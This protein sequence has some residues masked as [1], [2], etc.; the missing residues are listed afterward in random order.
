MARGRFVC[1]LASHSKQNVPSPSRQDGAHEMR[2]LLN[3][4]SSQQAQGRGLREHD[5][6]T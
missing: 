4:R 6:F 2:R 3:L 1:H 5:V